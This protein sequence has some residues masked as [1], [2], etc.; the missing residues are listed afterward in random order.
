MLQK[1]I[2]DITASPA[3]YI[4]AGDCSCLM[5]IQGGLDKQNCSRKTK[6]FI[7]ILAEAIENED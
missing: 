1:K 3:D 6:H 4:L 2:N 5:H 7:E